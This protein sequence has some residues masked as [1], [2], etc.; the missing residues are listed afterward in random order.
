MPEARHIFSLNHGARGRGATPFVKTTR[1]MANVV[2]GALVGAIFAL[3]GGIL[4]EQ[5]RA[6]RLSRVAAE[7]IAEELTAHMGVIQW[8][9]RSGEDD[10]FLIRVWEGERRSFVMGTRASRR[11]P[12]TDWYRSIYYNDAITVSSVAGKREQCQR[13]LTAAEQHAAAHFR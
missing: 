3:W 13:A 4:A 12:V 1:P 10:S 2:L 7:L 6:R 8:V 9:E 5:W 11:E